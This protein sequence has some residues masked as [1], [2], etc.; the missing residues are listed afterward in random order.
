MGRIDSLRTKL[1]LIMIL[2]IL[3]LMIVVGS[4]LLSGVSRFYIDRFYDSMIGTFSQEF[5]LSLQDTAA[6]S[7]NPPHQMTEMLMAQSLHPRPL[8]QYPRRQWT[9]NLS[10]CDG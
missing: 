4:F 2:L 3:A 10:A 8:R 1:V 5:I 7:P 6:E 9:G